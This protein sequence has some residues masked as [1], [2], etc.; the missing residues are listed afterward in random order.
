MLDSFASNQLPV[1]D[2]TGM[3]GKS[4]RGMGR[5]IA[6]LMTNTDTSAF[7]KRFP[8]DGEKF[9]ALLQP[10]R[11]EWTFTTV[12][13]KDG[14]FPAAADAFDGYVI[15]GSPASVNQSDAWIGGLLAF[16]REL[17]RQRI[18]TVGCCFGHQAIAR[19]LGGTVAKNPGGWGFGTAVTHFGR[20][21]PW[22]MPARDTLCL[23]SAHSEQVTKL[24]AGAVVLGGDAF[25]PISS[26]RIGAHFFTTQYHPEMSPEFITALTVELETQLDVATVERARQQLRKPAD[27][28]VF[29]EWMLRFLEF[30]R[31][32]SASG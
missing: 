1:W 12:P 2:E 7:A 15:T 13:V 5:R 23:Y 22:M 21:E 16:I 3:A 28:A 4:E 10:L 29:A 24:P 25:C 31:A 18:Q 32:P 14:V 6:I 26:F 11:P 30:S 8:D 20:E 19:A 9:T 27:G 17:D